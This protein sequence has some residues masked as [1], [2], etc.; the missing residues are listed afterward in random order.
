MINHPSSQAAE[1]AVISG[2][3]SS[4]VSIR[5]MPAGNTPSDAIPARSLSG[6]TTAL[7]NKMKTLSPVARRPTNTEHLSGGRQPKPASS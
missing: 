3:M 6:S 2:T 5:P 7:S 1:T 4:A